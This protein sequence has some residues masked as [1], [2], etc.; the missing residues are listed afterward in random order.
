MPPDQTVVVT[1]DPHV[2]WAIVCLALALVAAV[3][4]FA[5]GFAEDEE[6]GQR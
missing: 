1:F 6:R 2:T 4:A 3:L 5:F